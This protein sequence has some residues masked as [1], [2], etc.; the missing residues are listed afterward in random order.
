VRAAGDSGR[1]KIGTRALTEHLSE[2]AGEAV[3]DV[4]AVVRVRRHRADQLEAGL[5]RQIALDEE[6][7]VGLRNVGPATLADSRPIAALPI[8][9]KLA[10]E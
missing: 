4:H 5:G 7:F 8:V 9:P 6:R 2:I 10:R 3:R 1:L